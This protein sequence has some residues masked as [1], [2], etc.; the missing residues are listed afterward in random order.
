MLVVRGKLLGSLH[1]VPH[2]SSSGPCRRHGLG[3]RREGGEG[4][5]KPPFIFR[6]WRDGGCEKAETGGQGE[7]SC[8][9]LLRRMV[10]SWA[11][12]EMCTEALMWPE[13][14]YGTHS[15]PVSWVA[16]HHIT[17]ASSLNKQ[18]N[19]RSLATNRTQIYIVH[20]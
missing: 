7:R 15:W 14:R 4:L 19:P 2:C 17:T 16:V 1:T 10:V 13:E 6:G 3:R 18:A 5:E 12:R 8:A 11:G 9:T 20:F